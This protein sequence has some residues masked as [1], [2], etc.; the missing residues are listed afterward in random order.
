M[1]QY[2]K[3]HSRLYN[4]LTT[5]CLM[6]FLS[7]VISEGFCSHVLELLRGKGNEV[8]VPRSKELYLYGR[9]AMLRGKGYKL[10]DIL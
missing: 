4:K 1:S 8:N 10:E 3:E 9:E 7:F 2:T 5:L 6:T